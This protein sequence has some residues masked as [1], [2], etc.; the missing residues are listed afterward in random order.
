MGG[1][2]LAK[3]AEREPMAALLGLGLAVYVIG[4]LLSSTASAV[5]ETSSAPAASRAPARKRT[6]RR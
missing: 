3:R 5:S 6:R 2:M 4:S 1:R